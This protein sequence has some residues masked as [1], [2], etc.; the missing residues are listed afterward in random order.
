MEVRSRP[1]LAEHQDIQLDSCQEAF[2]L[3]VEATR[4]GGSHAVSK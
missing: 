3:K 4:Y 2:H 1:D